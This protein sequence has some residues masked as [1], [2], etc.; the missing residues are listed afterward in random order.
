MQ[1]P[2]QQSDVDESESAVDTHNQC[3]SEGTREDD[4][5]M[6][7]PSQDD[8]YHCR[9]AIIEPEYFGVAQQLRLIDVFDAPEKFKLR[10]INRNHVLSIKASMKTGVQP[11]PIWVV[12]CDKESKEPLCSSNFQ[13]ICVNGYCY[14]AIGTYMGPFLFCKSHYP[15]TVK[16]TGDQSIVGNY[17]I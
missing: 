12:V 15:F 6:A 11:L 17:F 10:A 9:R 14:M 8:E 1:F 3:S 7:D 4:E 16:C 5:S 2:L 13:S